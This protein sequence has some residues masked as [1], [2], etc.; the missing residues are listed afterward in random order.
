MSESTPDQKLVASCPHCGKTYVLLRES[1][2]RAARCRQCQQAFVVAE[3]SPGTTASDTRAVE[4]VPAPRVDGAAPADPPAGAGQGV[5]CPV[6]QSVIDSGEPLTVCSACHTRH[7][8]ECWDYNHGCGLYGCREA[9]ETEKLQDIEI[10]ASFWGQTEKKCPN[11]QKIIQAAA[12]RCRFCGTQFQTAR[13]REASEFHQEQRL[14]GSL[15]RHRNIAVALFVAALIPCTAPFAA[16]A[17]LIWYF[18]SRQQIGA[19][20]T[21]QASIGRIAIGLA[22]T[23]TVI[24]L[25][26]ASIYSALH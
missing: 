24:L 7:H 19:L 9:P 12:V 20:P 25:V 3:G 8:Q 23:V 1:L 18:T 5:L 10:P 13:P 22:V 17:G 26:L 16:I 2:G 4:S 6:C 15:P 14:K 21:L 11:C